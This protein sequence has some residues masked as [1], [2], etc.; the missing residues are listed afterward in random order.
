MKNFIDIL[1]IARQNVRENPGFVALSSEE[2]VKNCLEG[3]DDE[4]EEVKKEIRKENEVHL[5]DEL[6]DIA[7]DYARLLAVLER[8]GYI[9][10]AK[11]VLNHG[12]KKYTERLPAM[13]AG[14]EE[15]WDEIKQKQKEELK[16]NHEEKYG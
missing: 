9:A 8:D 7:W 13:L 1:N 11:E 14:G 3:I 16:R 5:V 12:V 6:S 10:D 15:L 2:A 4:V